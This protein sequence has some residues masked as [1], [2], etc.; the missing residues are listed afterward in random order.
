MSDKIYTDFWL[1]EDITSDRN[2]YLNLIRLAQYKRAIHNFVTILTEKNIP[3][4]FNSKNRNAT[5][6]EIIYL[7][8]KIREKRDFDET[9]GL[10]LHEAAHIVHSDFL[11]LQTI[12]QRIPRDLY[13]LSSKKNVSKLKVKNL[14][15]TMLNFVEDRFIDA[16]IYKEAPGYRGYYLALYDRYFNSPSKES[17]LKSNVYRY[18]SL[19]AYEFRII[20]LTNQTASDL[21]ALPGLREINDLIDMPNILRLTTPKHR[22]DVAIEVCKIII[23]NLG[24]RQKKSSDTKQSVNNHNQDSSE[25]G[26]IEKPDETSESKDPSVKNEDVLGGNDSEN[27]IQSDENDTSVDNNDPNNVETGM[28]DTSDVNVDKLNKLFEKQ[29]NF[30]NGDVKKSMLND[31]D[32][33]KFSTIEK[34]GIELTV[35]GKE[36]DSN[37]K[38]NG[39]ECVVVKRLTRELLMD[40]EFPMYNPDANVSVGI[41][42]NPNEDYVNVGLTMGRVLG[43][44]LKVRDEVKITKYTREK[45]GKI[46]RRI[47][48]ELGRDCFDVFFT[49][50]TDKFNDVYIHISVD[51][52]ASMIGKKWGKTISAVMAIC[53]AASM[54][55]NIKVSVSFR[56]TIRSENGELP[57]IVNAYDSTVDSIHDAIYRFKMLSPSN[58]TP[59]GLTFEAILDNFSYKTNGQDKFFLNFSDGQPMFSNKSIQLNYIGDIAVEHTRMQVLKIKNLG[60]KVLSYFIKCDS[61]SECENLAEI[62]NKIQS[63]FKRMYGRN[64][65]FIDVNNVTKISD[66]MNALFLKKD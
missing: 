19:D 32:L 47:L 43:K 66:T 57:Y 28:G 20:N 53:K 18:P 52:S 10:A 60:Y 3:I 54:I 25:S 7:S 56:T 29:R 36:L 2:S 17:D 34:S 23:N 40:E 61:E 48:S 55:N 42:K 30:I 5:N 26:S 35:V 49:T 9:V 14:V 21:D 16:F 15:K 33:K 4:Y 65:A 63:D 44:R 51:A 62:N 27:E 64:A 24:N 50:K 41:H 22:L 13:D 39:V 59:E 8:P 6:G 12:W 11:I 45:T 58:S 38:F 31:V 46:D 1:D 37:G